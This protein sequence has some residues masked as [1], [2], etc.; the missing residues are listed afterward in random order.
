MSLYSPT[1]A[2][3][4]HP[5]A[6]WR[7]T[8]ERARARGWSL[9]TFTGHAWGEIRCPSGKCKKKVYTSGEGQESVAKGTRQLVDRC[10]HQSGLTGVLDLIADRLDKAG[11]L[12]DAASA[13]AAKGEAERMIELLDEASPLLNE[14]AVWNE[15]GRLVSEDEQYAQEAAAAF[16][17]AG[18]AEM[19]EGDALDLADSR[20]RAVRADLKTQPAGVSRVKL[21]KAEADD[22]RG[23]IAAA[24]KR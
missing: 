22:L 16:V 19:S 17:D 13:L 6:P 7:D 24:R 14:D 21:L 8:L 18:E 9:R 10:P 1:D 4:E 11:R 2:W 15:F 23:R 5:K 3:P 20:V 12:V